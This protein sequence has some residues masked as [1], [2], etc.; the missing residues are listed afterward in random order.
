[1]LNK[2]TGVSTAPMK[3]GQWMKKLMDKR[4]KIDGLDFKKT[5]VLGKAGTGKTTFASTFPNWLFLDF[6]KNMRVIPDADKRRQFRIPFERGDDIE[7][8]VKDI[9][10][11]FIE[12]DEPFAPGGEFESVETIVIDSIHKMS[13]WMMYYIVSNNLKK[14]PKKDK[15]GF[16]GYNQLKNSWSEIVEKMKDAPCNI[17]ALTGV[18][19]YEKENEGTIEIQPMIEG[20]YRDMIAHE[21]G[22]VYYFDRELK[23]FGDKAV[24]NYIGY[25]NI[26]KNINMLKTTHKFENGSSIPYKF[27]NP[28]YERLY[29]KGEFA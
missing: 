10:Q 24:V 8:M 7:S 15:P 27:N 22:E 1:M 13:D 19:T 17:V 26:Y 18:R 9:F 3:K 21:F 28:T 2:Q 29:I 11:A 5:L 20:A 6:D 25:S 14:N 12:K 4:D 16:E 23:G